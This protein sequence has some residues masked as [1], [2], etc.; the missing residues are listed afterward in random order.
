[1]TS[2]DETYLLANN[3]IQCVKVTA[4]YYFPMNK[5]DTSAT[6]PEDID[7]GYRVYQIGAGW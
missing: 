4:K 6:T 3:K 5:A 2:C 7:I 1:M